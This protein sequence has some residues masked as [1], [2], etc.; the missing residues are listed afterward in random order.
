[1]TRLSPECFFSAERRL[2]A[3]V[4]WKTGI[5]SIAA[6]LDA[7]GLSTSLGRSALCGRSRVRYARLVVLVSS[8]P[9]LRY[10]ELFQLRLAAKAIQKRLPALARVGEVVK[11]LLLRVKR[12]AW[13]HGRGLRVMAAKTCN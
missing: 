1:M 6:Q 4:L 12:A 3:F 2:L 7:M 5:T 11:I 8:S 13:P 10:R 9:P